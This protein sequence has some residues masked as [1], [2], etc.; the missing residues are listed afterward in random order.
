MICEICGKSYRYSC[1]HCTRRIATWGQDGLL[2]LIELSKTKDDISAEDLIKT[3][4]TYYTGKASNLTDKANVLKIA[5]RILGYKGKFV[6]RIH[7]NNSSYL[8]VRQRENQAGR[9]WGLRNS[10][11]DK[12]GSED[13][14][15]LHHIV[16]LSW[17]GISSPENCATLCESCHRKVHKELSQLLT[18]LKLIEYLTPHAEEIESLAKR[19]MLP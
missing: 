12:C 4:N 9:R 18:R 17:G 14:L 8:A 2:Y 16:P 11:C 15:R 6:G 5:L 10:T 19:S 1:A 3:V 13:Q 7:R